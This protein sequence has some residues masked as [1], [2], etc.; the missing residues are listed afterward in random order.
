MRVDLTSFIFG[1]VTGISCVAAVQY[2]VSVSCK[3][4]KGKSR[5]KAPSSPIPPSPMPKILTSPFDSTTTRSPVISTFN[6]LETQGI[7]QVIS[8]LDKKLVVSSSKLQKIVLHMVSEFKKGLD[9]DKEIFKMIPSYVESRPTGNETGTFLALD[10][11]GT[12]F[13]VCMVQLEGRGSIRMSHKKFTVSEVLKKGSGEQLFDFFAECVALFCLENHLDAVNSQLAMGFTFSFPVNQTCINHGKLV[14]WTKGFECNGV[15][16]EDVVDILNAAFAKRGLKIEIKALINDTVGTLIAHSYVD[17]QTFISVILGTG[18]N[19]AYVEK[20][21]NI[22]KWSKEEGEVIIN[23]EWGAYNEASVLPITEYDS[24][25][26]RK[27][28]NPTKQIFEKMISG[29]YL[30]EI[31]RLIIDDLTKTGELFGANGSTKLE[32][33]NSFETAHMSRI[34]RYFE[35]NVVIIH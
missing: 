6:Q 11:G 2:F 18:T 29:M 27:S 23:T 32:T 26:D 9:S 1:I 14:K 22:G 35:Y 28:A 30:G 5:S 25:M 33:P 21:A 19:A 15:E 3:D 20:S 4:K 16:G 31:T 13:R 8:K 7:L 12:N 24:L 10:L 34:E 17:P